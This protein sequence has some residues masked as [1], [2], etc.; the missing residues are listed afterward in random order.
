MAP[1]AR[2]VGFL[3]LIELL[4][5]SAIVS[6][7]LR[8]I[9]LHSSDWLVSIAYV[10]RL[11]LGVGGGGCPVSSYYDSE[12]KKVK[13]DP[14]VKGLYSG[15][16]P[17]FLIEPLPNT[18]DPCGYPATVTP[19]LATGGAPVYP[20]VLSASIEDARIKSGESTRVLVSAT[21][22]DRYPPPVPNS[23]FVPVPVTDTIPLS[24]TLYTTT[25]DYS[26]GQDSSGLV[27]LDIEQPANFSW[28]I[29]PKE[30]VAGSQTLEVGLDSERFD[31]PL[32]PIASAF[33]LD[34][35]HVTGLNVTFVGI[36]GAVGTF[37]AGLVGI[38]RYFPDIWTSYRDWILNRRSRT[39]PLGFRTPHQEK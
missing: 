8:Y 17:L 1:R 27:S 14:I 15:P 23:I 13:Y 37:L 11:P 30:R 38:A 28:I 26:P 10:E 5:L 20:L 3:L 12:G 33:H 35:R 19:T 31:F 2:F 34:V 29:S 16:A 7:T 24:F 36:V 25:F 4:I 6:L 22:A 32:F 9:A 21:L 39:A 18:S